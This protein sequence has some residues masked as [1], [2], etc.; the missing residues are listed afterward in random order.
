MKRNVMISG[1]FTLSEMT[2][3]NT[4]A[5]A[6]K[7]TK[8]AKARIEALKAAGVDTSNYF[9]MGEEMVIKVVDGVPTQVLDDDPI[10]QSIT[11]GGYLNHY[12]LYRRFVMSQMFHILRDMEKKDKSFN[13]LIQYRGYEYQWKVVENELYAQM[14]M[15]KNNDVQSLSGRARWFNSDSV[16]MMAEDYIKSLK[17]YIDKSLTYRIDRKGVRKFKHT[18]KGHPYIRLGGEC[19][20]VLDVQRKVFAP[21][22]KACYAIENS[23]TATELYVNVF[24]FNKMRKSL[25]WD[26]KHSDAF[27]NAYKGSGSYYTM[28]NLIMFHGARFKGAPTQEKSLL[29]VEENANEY[30]NEGW[31]M[32]GVL[33]QLISDSGISVE[34]K[35]REWRK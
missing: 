14:K 23:K 6:K 13:S 28:R 22:L 2:G 19:I 16:A 8:N 31:R 25:K 29:L 15:E 35:I 1:E 32:L 17:D 21:L 33:K 10:F 7:G 24:K 30:I 12:K 34:G 4:K 9:P 11:K 5:S 27:I 18:C 20:F 26:T 3:S